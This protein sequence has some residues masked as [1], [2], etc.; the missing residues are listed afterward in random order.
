M[1]GPAVRAKQRGVVLVS[2][3][4]SMFDDAMDGVGRRLMSSLSLPDGGGGLR[5]EK[6][7][8]RKKDMVKMGPFMSS[9]MGFGTCTMMELNE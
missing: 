2:A 9:P 3:T 6:Q 4:K 7:L 8:Y 1:R 5:G